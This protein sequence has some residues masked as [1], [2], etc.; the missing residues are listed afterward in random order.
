MNMEGRIDMSE[1][2]I[3][4]SGTRPR[5][6]TSWCFGR[7]AHHALD[8]LDVVQFLFIREG[9]PRL[10]VSKIAIS[11]TFLVSPFFANKHP[12]RLTGTMVR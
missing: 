8:A 7:F 12:L 6:S 11:C 3:I 10:V 2:E 5:S 9:A 4:V 1:D